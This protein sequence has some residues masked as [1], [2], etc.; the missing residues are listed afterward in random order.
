MFFD[1][2]NYAYKENVYDVDVVFWDRENEKI[3]LKDIA[4]ACK[5][6]RRASS[7]S[8]PAD[9]CKAL[10]KAVRDIFIFIQAKQDPFR[11]MVLPKILAIIHKQ[12]NKHH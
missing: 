2:V 11:F 8:H 9:L 10:I 1:P 7:L 5:E 6:F 4:T 12:S 3:N